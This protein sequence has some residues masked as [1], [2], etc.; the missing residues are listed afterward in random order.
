MIQLIAEQLTRLGLR[1]SWALLIADIG[2]VVALLVLA[3]LV[4]WIAKRVILRLVAA[5]VKRS[6]LKSDDILFRNHVF[7]RLSHVAPALVVTTLGPSFFVRAARLSQL[8][9]LGTTLYLV[10]I[11]LT[12]LSALLSS[13][14][15][16]YQLKSE[17]KSAPLKSFV[18]GA[19]LVL[20]LFGGI[21]MLSITLGRSPVYFLSGLGAATAVLLLIFKDAIL[22]LV[23]GVQ[24][25]ATRTVQIGDWIEMPKFG[26][27]GDVIDIG[28]TTVRVQNWDKTISTV[29]TYA[30]ISEPVKN[31]RGMQ[32]AGG[33]RIKRSI[34]LD[35][36][37]FKFLD[38]P[39]TEKLLQIERLRP[40][41]EE[42]LEEVEAW[43]QE[44]GLTGKPS[45]NT[46]RLTNVGCF[47]AYADAYLR[48]H[49]GINQELTKLVRH[50]APT[51]KGLPLELYIFTSD[52]SWGAYEATQ[53]DVFDH[54]LTI[55][56]EFDL[57][58]YQSPSS[59][60]LKQLALRAAPHG[61]SGSAD[62]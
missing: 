20:W 57:E 48:A 43:N 13:G 4:N 61:D 25:S 40:Y 33:R 3:W 34:V 42:K 12:V 5:F 55:A 56:K 36:Q 31:W 14:F 41:L 59:R 54:L 1:P 58:V 46:R 27:D 6:R 8:L 53:A 62:S 52:I 45:F 28:L 35:I 30:L 23:A 37:S 9:E 2:G 16:I 18:Q 39:L 50:L 21:V 10:W 44:H 17:N 38:E 15:E 7:T 51:D 32:E 19:K 22:G 24:L 26:A 60:D 11:V 29:P 47:R 49:P